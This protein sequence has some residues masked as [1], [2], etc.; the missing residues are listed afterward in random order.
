CRIATATER[1][2][3][4]EVT[5]GCSF[6]IVRLYARRS[7]TSSG[8]SAVAAHQ[9]QTDCGLCRLRD[10]HRSGGTSCDTRFRGP[11]IRRNCGQ[12]QDPELS[13]HHGPR[14]QSCYL[15]GSWV[16]LW[17]GF[18]RRKSHSTVLHGLP[19]RNEGSRSHSHADSFAGRK[20]GATDVAV[21]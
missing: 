18:T 13:L 9:W 17:F 20:S 15:V 7:G 4:N 14:L 10:E 16:D 19:F 8:G 6:A 1:V 21:I 11:C 2:V 3:Q 12:F 5:V